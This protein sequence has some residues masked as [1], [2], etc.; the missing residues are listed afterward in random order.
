MD[1]LPKRNAVIS[2]EGPDKVTNTLE[3]KPKTL[4]HQTRH[5]PRQ[6]SYG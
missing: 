6:A 3:K 5:W 2:A 1:K 4:G